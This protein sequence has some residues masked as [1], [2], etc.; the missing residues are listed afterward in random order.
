MKLFS[1]FSGLG[2]FEIGFKQVYGKDLEVVGY[3]EIDKYAISVY[4][5]QFPGIKNFGDA[6]KIVPE[7]IPDFDI[8]TGGLPCQSWSIAGKRKGFEDARGTMWY[9]AFR[10][11]NIKKPKFLLFE[12]VKGLISHN[13][14]KSIE[15]IL[16][17]ICDLGYAMDFEIL[18][19]KNYG[20]PQNR[21]RVFIMCVRED[22]LEKDQII[23][24]NPIED[25]SYPKPTKTIDK[26]K[27]R[28]LCNPKIK[29]IPFNF[30]QGTAG[31][32]RLSDIIENNVDQKYY[33]SEKMVNYLMERTKQTKDHHKPNIVEHCEAQEQ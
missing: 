1:M 13:K 24:G 26:I 29:M 25:K 5:K 28:L 30:P 23:Y 6:T 31:I 15:Q 33:L 9:E 27:E 20:V 2:G 16:E 22:L 21:E 12:N 19:S 7:D 8:L 11:T 4:E 32:C 14:G 10:I 18:N 3:S 17:C